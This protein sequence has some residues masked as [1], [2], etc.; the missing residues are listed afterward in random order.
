MR[1][2]LFALFV[3]ATC[4]TVFAQGKVNCVNDGASLVVLTTDTSLLKPADRPLAGQAVGNQVLLPSG[5]TLMAGLYG[6]TVSSSLFLYS[7]VALTD[8]NT[9]GGVILPTHMVLTANAA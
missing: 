2:R 8:P 9:P 1:K 6:G 3:A 7:T 5:I 4:V